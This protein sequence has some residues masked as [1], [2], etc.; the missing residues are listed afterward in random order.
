[1]DGFLE[2]LEASFQAAFGKKIGYV[3]GI[4]EKRYQYG[5]PEG[6]YRSGT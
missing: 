6:F 4:S 1:M 5:R 3:T 2:D